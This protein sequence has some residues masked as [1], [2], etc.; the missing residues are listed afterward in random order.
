MMWGTGSSA[1]L[2]SGNNNNNKNYLDLNKVSLTG[3][4]CLE[5]L[6]IKMSTTEGEIIIVIVCI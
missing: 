4:V 1:L 2:I 6:I 3:N 5:I